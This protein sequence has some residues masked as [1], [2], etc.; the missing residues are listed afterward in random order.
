MNVYSKIIAVWFTLS[1]SYQ[2]SL[3]QTG[4]N[5]ASAH[6]ISSLPFSAAGLSSFATGNSYSAPDACASPFMEGNDYLFSYTPSNNVPI[7]I[8]LDS[9]WPQTGIFFLDGCPDAAGTSCLGSAN[10]L[11][12]YINCMD[13]SAGT[14]YYILVDCAAGF[15]FW[16]PSFGINVEEVPGL[17]AAP[18]CNLDYTLSN[19]TYAP[20]SYFTGTEIT[21]DDDVFGR[22]WIE[23]G[24]NFCF[25]G[26]EYQKCLISSNGYLTFKTCDANQIPGG[27]GNN[28]DPYGFSPWQLTA[29]APNTTNCPRNSILLT[30]QD[31]APDQADPNANNEVKYQT[32]GSSPNRIFIL[33]YND[34]K[35][36]GCAA[37][38]AQNYSAQLMLYESTNLIEFHTTQRVPCNSWLGGAGIMGIT[39]HDGTAAEIVPGHNYS[40]N[41]TESSTAYRFTPGGCTGTCSIP[42]SISLINFTGEAIDNGNLLQWSTNS[43]EH[44][45]EF[46]IEKSFDGSSFVKIATIP[47]AGNSNQINQY[48]VVDPEFKSPNT[49]YRLKQVN[50]EGI[51]RQIKTIV[52]ARNVDRKIKIYPNPTSTY[53]NV[54]IEMES[55]AN[56]RIQ[57]TNILGVSTQYEK[58]LQK[59]SNEFRLNEFEQLAQGIYTVKIM[60]SKG[61]I[62]AID[63]VVKK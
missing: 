18:P 24:F 36:Y 33:K 45:K 23:F 20:A 16:L 29:N 42:L 22:D 5:C 55:K 14:T 10:G 6:N 7:D 13:V 40:D 49:Y 37:S 32:V 25:D 54:A 41:W 52:V 39:N 38:G 9:D 21:Y 58:Q 15:P 4:T 63:K 47:G 44:N 11:D 19:I 59:G 26:S 51:E 57:I 12:A 56:C 3:S 1:M 46:F 28:A 27:S 8:Y 43:E 17:G 61:E 2:I 35:L 60:N 34:I 62:I 53:F 50:F 48:E 30:W 31:I